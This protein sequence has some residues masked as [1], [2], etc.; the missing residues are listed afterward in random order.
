M[1]SFNILL[2]CA[3]GGLSA[4]LRRRILLNKRYDIKLI[5]VDNQENNYAKLF[6]NYF[7]KVPKGSATSYISAISKIIKKYD[8]NLVIPCSDEEAISLAKNRVS[9]ESSSCT[10]AC[11]AY[12]T[13]NI[14]SNK[15]ETYKI[16]QKNN[17]PVPFFTSISNNEELVKIELYVAKYGQMIMKPAVS[18]GGRNIITI[19][20]NNYKKYTEQNFYIKK[21]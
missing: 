20:K 5:S 18:R 9:I 4:E 15:L 10:L 17:I 1:S 13:L 3:G 19:N 16:L 21:V 6:S 2:T 11:T 7:E 12:A 8:V 14:L